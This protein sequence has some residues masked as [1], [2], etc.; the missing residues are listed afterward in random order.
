ME[1]NRINFAKLQLLQYVDELFIAICSLTSP[2]IEEDMNMSSHGLDD[3]ELT[4]ILYF[5]FS[6]HFLV[7]LHQDRGLFTP[8]L[9]ELTQALTEPFDA[10]SKHTFYGM[11]S[12]AHELY[13]ELKATY[14]IKN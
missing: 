9:D 5:L 13:K 10:V 14:G 7:A 3:K 12:A 2:N 8:T 1:K 4:I 11:T 6:E